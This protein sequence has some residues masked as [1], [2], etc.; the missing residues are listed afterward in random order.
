MKS[1]L[2]LASAETAVAET[3]DVI[4]AMKD[5]GATNATDEVRRAV[6]ELL[7]LKQILQL[8]KETEAAST[9]DA[10]SLA[11]KESESTTARW[12]S[13]ARRSIQELPIHNLPERY[14]RFTCEDRPTAKTLAKEIANERVY[15]LVTDGDEDEGDEE[16]A[17]EGLVEA[18]RVTA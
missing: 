5:A 17:P 13:E 16:V 8:L 4:R 1:P 9:S 12:Q 10:V 15:H 7:A 18:E 6:A 14:L 11:E 2:S 3:A